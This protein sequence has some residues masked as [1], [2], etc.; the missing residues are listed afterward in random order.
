MGKV[1]LGNAACMYGAEV[2]HVS[3]V[4]RTQN[5]SA[6]AAASS[7]ASAFFTVRGQNLTKPPTLGVET[8]RAKSG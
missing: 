6:A 7:T 2:P 1:L 4:Q 8:S 3:V 5:T